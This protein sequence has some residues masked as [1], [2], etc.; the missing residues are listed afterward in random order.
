[1]TVPA[2]HNP[3]PERIQR[4][5]ETPNPKEKMTRKGKIRTETVDL[6]GLDERPNPERGEPPSASRVAV[7]GDLKKKKVDETDF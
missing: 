7:K 3:L 5:R 4:N 6:P 2:V 1:M